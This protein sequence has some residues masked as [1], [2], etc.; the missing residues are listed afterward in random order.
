MANATPQAIGAQLAFPDRQVIATCGDGGLTM[1]LGD[2]STITTYNLS[3]KLIVF[4]NSLLDM[5]RWEMLA[6]GYEPFQTD[7]HNPDFVR[8]AE[9]YGMFSVGVER[10][11]DVPAAL[12]QILSHPGP[13]LL[14]IKTLGLATALPQHPSWEQIKGFT[15]ASAKLIVHGRADQVVDLARESL[16]DIGQLPGVPAPPAHN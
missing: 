7:L 1:L 16:R 6:E 12:E 11:D 3:I 13:A 2:L 5:V 10:H 4:D 8:L 14:S 15:K 9:A